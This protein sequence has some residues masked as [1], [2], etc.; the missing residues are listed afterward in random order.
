[1]YLEKQREDRLKEIEAF[2]D[3]EKYKEE[4][5]MPESDYTIQVRFL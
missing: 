5:E 1:M 4:L 3:E 2:F